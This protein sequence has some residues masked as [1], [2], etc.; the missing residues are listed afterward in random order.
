MGYLRQ[1]TLGKAPSVERPRVGDVLIVVGIVAVLYAGTR[2]ATPNPVI[3]PEINLSPA[4]LPYYGL[5]SLGRMAASY[6]LS[7]AFAVTFGYFAAKSRPAE[8]IMMPILDILQ[9]VPL[10]AF[11]PVVLLVLTT[12]LPQRIGVEVSAVV[13]IFTSQAWNIAYSFYQSVRT[14]PHELQEASDVYKFNWWYRLRYLELPFGLNGL[15][16]NSVVSWANGWFFLMAAET[17]RIGDRDFRLLGLGSYLQAAAE[18]GDGTA[19]LFGFGTLVLLV[20]M[21][22]QLLWRPL[23]SWAN[24]FRVDLVENDDPPTS[25][26]YNLLER[27]RIAVGITEYLIVPIVRLLDR[28]FGGARKLES[29]PRK[30]RFGIG[31]LILI[32]A[33]LVLIYGIIQTAG[34]LVALP[35]E[36]WGN[37]LTATLA[38]GARVAVAAIIGLLWTIP[39][40]VLIGTNPRLSSILQPVVQVMAAI[41]ATA[42]FPVIV[43]FMVNLPAGLDGA[44][45]LLMLLGTQWYLL[46]NIIAGASTIPQDLTDITRMYRITGWERWRTLIL[47]AIFP[48]IITGLNIAGGGAW[49]ASIVAE[50]TEYKGAIY[51]VHGLGSIIT[52]STATGDYNMLL[53]ATLAMILTVIGLNYFVWNRLHHYAAEKYRLD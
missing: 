36:S 29:Q 9:S 34:S 23:L 1:R 43:L 5:L 11:L 19:I 2:L 14:V 20:V 41:P 51:K 16:W 24:K 47:P 13:L 3:G 44:A 48:Y 31:R 28:R 12:L 32:G 37:I 25:W 40:G 52:Q 38:T 22:D 39:V 46:F 27:S 26:F 17:F 8:R 30:R 4:A 50:I 6:V 7:L 21:L 49:N 10:L 45:V 42:L 53:A 15:L 33:V 18:A 35:P